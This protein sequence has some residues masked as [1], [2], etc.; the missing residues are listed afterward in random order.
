M[1]WFTVSPIPIKRRVRFT[2]HGKAYTDEKTRDD[3][4]RVRDSYKGEFFASDEPLALIIDVYKPIPKSKP[5]HAR[6]PFTVKP[7]VDNIAK[8]VLD[9]LNGK[10]FDD[11]RQVVLMTIYKHDRTH[12]ILSEQ[13]RYTLCPFK[14]VAHDRETDRR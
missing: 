9:G 5:K 7:D 4:A 6:E 13:I 1:L 3:L 12:D 8:A 2:Q 10:A 14:E 11:D